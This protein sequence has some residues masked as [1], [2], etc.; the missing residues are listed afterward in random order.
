MIESNAPVLEDIKNIN[1]QKR[2]MNIRTY[3]FSTLFTKIP[4]EGDSR[5]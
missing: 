1:D 2:A 5:R 3:D 4:N